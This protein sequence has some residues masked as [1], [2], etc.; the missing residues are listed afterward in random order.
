MRDIFFIALVTI[1]GVFFQIIINGVDF[2]IPAYVLYLQENK[3]RYG[4]ISG[5]FWTLM[6]EG[7]SSIPFGATFLVYI[8]IFVFFFWLKNYLKSTTIFFVLILAGISSI[9]YY[10]SISLITNMNDLAINYA[11]LN[12]NI[13]TNLIVFPFTWSLYSFIYKK[14]FSYSKELF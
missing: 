8:I 11:L 5:L 14:Y 12:H 13:F 10:I 4:I 7:L 9:T 3:I 1:L 2:Y 6:L